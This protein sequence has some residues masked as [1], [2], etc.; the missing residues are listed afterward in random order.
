M[1]GLL[2]E[3]GTPCPRRSRGSR[4]SDESTATDS[5]YGIW[6]ESLD[7]YDDT[8]NI[9]FTTEI[10]APILT[11]T[12]PKRRGKTSTSFAIHSD[13]SEKPQAT[14][15]PKKDIKPA[16]ASS[17]RQPSLL[18]AP[19][20]RFRPRV[21]FAPSP[22]KHSQF[23]DKVE[24]KKQAEPN[25]QRNNDLL[26]RISGGEDEAFSRD[27]LKQDVRR[28][29]I[30]IPPG[31]TT[32]ASVFMGIFS[33]LKKGDLETYQSENT[34]VGS[35]E[36]QIAKKQ[37]ATQSSTSS[38]GLPLQ[39]K[40]N[41]AQESCSKFDIPGKNGGKE[42]IPPGMMEVNFNSS[43]MNKPFGKLENSKTAANNPVLARSTVKPLAAKTA[44]KPVKINSQNGLGVS[45]SS[46][47]SGKQ[48]LNTRSTGTG[49]RSSTLSRPLKPSMS[50]TTTSRSC[51]KQLNYECPVSVNIT[52]PVMYDDDWLSHQEVILTQLINGL[53]DDASCSAPDDPV[54]LRQEL[55]ALYQSPYFTNLYKR[56]QASLMYGALS[57]PKDVLLRNSR[58]RQDLGMKRKFIDIWL[59]TYEPTAL[60]AAL[61]T[62]TGRV[63]SV[64][65][66]SSSSILSSRG[67]DLHDE[68]LLERR[69][70]K[71]LDAFLI[72]S[73]DVERM[74]SDLAGDIDALAVAY[75][76]TVLRS[77]MMIILLDKARDCKSS[78][79]GPLFL[80]SSL[81]KSSFAVLKALARFL[82]P[83]CGDVGKVLSQLNCQL[84]YEQHP[85]QEY[86]Y[87]V[88]NLAVDIR[89]GVRLTRMMELLLY[90]S[91]RP[92]NFSLPSAVASSM[93]SDNNWPL[94]EQLKFPCL[95]RAVKMFNVK[96]ALEKLSSTNGGGPLVSNIRA[97]DIVDGHR[98]KTIALLWGLFSNWGLS[99]LIDIDDLRKEICQLRQ[100]TCSIHGAGFNTIEEKPE[101]NE[102]ELLRQWASLV[103]ESKGLHPEDLAMN[104]ANGQVYQC[105]LDEYGDYSPSA[106]NASTSKASLEDRLRALGCS[107]QFSKFH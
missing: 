101:R 9:D 37:Q 48:S 52:N 18:S 91:L 20:Q 107:T 104:L 10:K 55:L 94:S 59:Q 63:I 87:K 99:G 82:L 13:Y 31:D 76:R 38:P 35:L 30:Y 49:T 67:R 54:M 74:N 68:K 34:K 45:V 36:C 97:A 80:S 103:A 90:P 24:P 77:L 61:E 79:S 75:R 16:I 92:R 1:S 25:T 33:P 95:G 39:P 40:L 4:T 83:S 60:R 42:N 14:A 43:S 102:P 44:N 57:I 71:F 85:L 66:T 21:S 96:K 50:E 8:R 26:K 19:A 47:A 72:R 84:I 100:K 32:V 58:L 17:N 98:E 65:T 5:F 53:F 78:L 89:D 105:I 62:V 46:N 64:P 56:L 29:T 73:Q 51:R 81:Y 6:D 88:A 93:N 23:R 86:N 12:K 41:I 69:L 11:G 2:Q 70:A 27:G 22:P 106:Q 15:A 3:V 28:N 7:D